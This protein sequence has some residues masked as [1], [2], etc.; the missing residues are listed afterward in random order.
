MNGLACSPGGLLVTL[1]VQTE[2]AALSAFRMD[3]TFDHLRANLPGQGTDGLDRF[4]SLL[5]DPESDD[6]A[7]VNDE[8]FDAETGVAA[9]VNKV[10]VAFAKDF[11]SVNPQGIGQTNFSF[12]TFRFDCADGARFLPSDFRCATSQNANAAG[13]ELT[14]P[15]T[16]T[17]AVEPAPAPAPSS[18][19]VVHARQS[20]GQSPKPA[21]GK[22]S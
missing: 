9:D 11:G 17:A 15:A 2:A 5:P 21:R 19:F 12:A 6:F 3:V 4:A 20:P 16:C 14:P 13:A 1:A 7:I 8:L 10:R 22:H 18:L